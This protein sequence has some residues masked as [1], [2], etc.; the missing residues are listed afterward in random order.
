MLTVVPVLKRLLICVAVA[1]VLFSLSVATAF[2]APPINDLR[3]S[4][5]PLNVPQKVNGTTV[6]A[7][8]ESGEPQPICASSGPESVWYSLK[9]TGKR[10]ALSLEANGDL[11]AVVAVYERVR[12]TTSQVEC[13]ATDKKGIGVLAFK[14]KPNTDYAI[15]VKPRSG[16]VQGTFSLALATASEPADFPGDP[17]PSNG[18]ANT[19]DL[20]RNPSDAWA[21]TFNAGTTYR[22]N[23]STP[24]GDYC[25]K[26]SLFAKG[27]SDVA[28]L[29]LSCS[30]G[31]TLFTPDR[32]EGGRFTIEIVA[33]KSVLGA[34]HYHL[35]T[36]RAGSDDTGP[37]RFW[38]G[39]SIHGYLDGHGIDNEDLYNWDLGH[40]S[41]VN[42]SVSNG[43]EVQLRSI[44]GRNLGC[45]CSESFPRTLKPGTYFASV[46][47]SSNRTGSYTLK[48][49]VRSITHTSVSFN[50]GGHATVAPGQSVTITGKVT[51]ASRGGI[52]ITLERKDPVYGWQYERSY[53]GSGSSGSFSVSFTPPGVGEWRATADFKGSSTAKPSES[54]HAHLSVRR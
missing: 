49:K 17:L 14:T 15:V 32:G 10:V 33:A 5:T 22:L 6:E 19:V 41:D 46:F 27:K 12:S 54:G 9:G 28:V 44:G 30:D 48:R 45:T 31:Y 21:V 11:D 38:A 25:V 35:Q 3:A 36:A 50:G 34:Q 29:R 20:A 8:S 18:T 39:L 24:S 26:A 23:L 52:R 53:D 47:A 2:A 40:K 37:G 4:A 13:A 7:T 43:F 16:S 51:P 1:A 42:L